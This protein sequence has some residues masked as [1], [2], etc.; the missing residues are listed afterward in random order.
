MTVKCTNEDW[1][2]SRYQRG[3][4]K[5]PAKWTSSRASPQWE[6]GDGVHWHRPV[7]GGS[8]TG[9]ET[10][11]W[12]LPG[13]TEAS[14]VHLWVLHTLEKLN[15]M[16][17]I[18]YWSFVTLYATHSS[19][20]SVENLGQRKLNTEVW[21]IHSIIIKA[22]SLCLACTWIQASAPQKKKK[23]KLDSSCP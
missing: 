1:R 11:S 17:Y 22:V 5:A 13:T 6:L 9:S 4:G 12:K 19:Q 2:S 18:V 8:S 16:N 10:I 15:Y 14:A 7:T 21:D 23:K 20:S 3:S